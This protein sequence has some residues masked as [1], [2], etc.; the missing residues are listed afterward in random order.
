MSTPGSQQAGAGPQGQGAVMLDAGTAQILV[1]LGELKTAVGVLD[2]RVRHIQGDRDDHEARI[3]SLESS[4]VSSSAVE[5][6]Q[7]R[8]RQAIWAAVGSLAGA[9]ATALTL[10]GHL[11]G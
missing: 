4:T 10:W 2:E 3:R 11:H 5:A 8:S 9:I 7:R 6:A 1:S